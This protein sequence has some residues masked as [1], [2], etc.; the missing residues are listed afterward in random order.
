MLAVVQ[1][2]DVTREALHDMNREARWLREYIS[3][4]EVALDATNGET[5]EAKAAAAAA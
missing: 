3:A 2:A 5:V 1:E 4:A